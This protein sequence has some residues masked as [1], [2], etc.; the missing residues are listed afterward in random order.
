[1]YFPSVL[2]IHPLP[3]IIYVFL[4]IFFYKYRKFNDFQ[5]CLFKFIKIQQNS[6]KNTSNEKVIKLNTINYILQLSLSFLLEYWFGKE[7]E[8]YSFSPLFIFLSVIIFDFV[9]SILH[10]IFHYTFLFKK[11][12][13]IHHSHT[14]PYVLTTNYSHP[15]ESIFVNYLSIL[16]PI[17]IF[18]K[19]LSILD[20]CIYIFVITVHTS[21]CHCGYKIFINNNC[22][23]DP[24]YHDEHHYY[25]NKNYS[26]FPFV[27]KILLLIFHL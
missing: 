17:I 14:K 23:I 12:H 18:D 25:V 11:F 24:S 3:L 2:F 1:M 16:T 10:R 19:V 21:L 8:I 9:F 4:S 27:D 5:C 15:V 22:I 6:Q 7:R 26:T 20:R 13:Y